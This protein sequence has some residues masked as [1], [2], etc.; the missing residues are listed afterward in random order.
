MHSITTSKQE[1]L[2]NTIV[3]SQYAIFTTKAI[4]T[5][6]SKTEDIFV[7][8]ILSL[9]ARQRVQLYHD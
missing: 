5:K 9:F 2:V 7:N 1:V 6:G 8:E 4:H 3:S